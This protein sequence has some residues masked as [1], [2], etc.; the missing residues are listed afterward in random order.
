MAR[1]GDHPGS[2]AER[3]RARHELRQDWEVRGASIVSAFG[4]LCPAGLVL[5]GLV[6]GE[7]AHKKS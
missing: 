2:K 4:A 3:S 6:L 5:R 7:R 1:C